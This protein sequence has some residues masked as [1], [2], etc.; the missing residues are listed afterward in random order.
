[1]VLML[2]TSGHL[3][4]L[5]A[6]QHDAVEGFS[7]T[8]AEA[9]EDLRYNSRVDASQAMEEARSEKRGAL[10]FDRGHR[11]WLAA[12][13]A[14]RCEIPSVP[15][16]GVWGMGAPLCIFPTFCVYGSVALMLVCST[17]PMFARAMAM[18]LLSYSCVALLL[19]LSI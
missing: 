9:M 14:I 17:T 11:E 5:R 12:P 10:T 3:R 8:M 6:A 2:D 15:P 1:M 18:A 4:H 7:R 13:R 16:T 19:F